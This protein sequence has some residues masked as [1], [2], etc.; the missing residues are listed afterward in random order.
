MEY[1]KGSWGSPVGAGPERPPKILMLLPFFFSSLKNRLEVLDGRGLSGS[2]G[3]RF[4]E[5]D[6][7]KETH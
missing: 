2:A 6:G 5:V 7:T 4:L 1:S 3:R